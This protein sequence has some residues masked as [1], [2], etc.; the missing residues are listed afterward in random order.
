V[1]RVWNHKGST[2]GASSG[3]FHAYR[4]MKRSEA[5]RRTELEEEEMEVKFNELFFLEERIRRI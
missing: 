4:R 3:D 1:E 2:S 5:L